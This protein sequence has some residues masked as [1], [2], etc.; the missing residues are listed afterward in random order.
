MTFEWLV[1]H[2]LTNIPLHSG[3]LAES[4]L[5]GLPVPAHWTG[6]IHFSN[7]S[8]DVP[9]A[10]FSFSCSASTLG[11][12]SATFGRSASQAS[13]LKNPSGISLKWNL[14]FP[15][16]PEIVPHAAYYRFPLRFMSTISWPIANYT[17]KDTL[18]SMTMASTYALHRN[19][20][21]EVIN[22]S[23]HMQWLKM[24]GWD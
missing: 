23:S 15:L 11:T 18:I 14:C 8:T 6:R 10:S 17:S 20:L 12:M 22:Y 13:T 16:M 3:Y 1:N 7:H 21:G 24:A 19:W 2:Y 5:Y 9:T 4:T